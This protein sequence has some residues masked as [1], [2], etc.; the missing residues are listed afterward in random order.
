MGRKLKYKPGSFYRVDDRTGF[1]QRAERTKKEWNGLIVDA[2]VWEPRQPQDLVR[3]VPDNQSVEDAR[4]LA[5]DTFV[6]PLS[7]ALTANAAVR[8]TVVQV[9][10]TQGLNAG[11]HIGIMLDVGVIFRTTISVAPSGFNVTLAAPLPS[12]AASGN[13]LTDYAPQVSINAQAVP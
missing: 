13:L 7:V 8:A 3:G 12:S 6:G 1:P 10:S 5:P 4:P 11:D 2:S 9:A